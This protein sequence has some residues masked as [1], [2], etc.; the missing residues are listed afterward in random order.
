MLRPEEG[1]EYRVVRDRYRV[2]SRG[3]GEGSVPVTSIEGPGRVDLRVLRE[4]Y[5]QGRVD[6]GVKG[7]RDG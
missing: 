2:Q 1:V 6:E 4:G 3:P 5:R 7:G